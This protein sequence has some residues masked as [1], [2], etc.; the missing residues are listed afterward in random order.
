VVI[1][2]DMEQAKSKSRRAPEPPKRIT[3]VPTSHIAEESLR[4]IEAIV[5]KEKPDCIAV[6][7]DMTRFAAMKMGGGR[8]SIRELGIGSFLVFWLMK[9]IQDW[10]GKKVGIL[11]GSEMLRAVELAQKRKTM[12]FFIDREIQETFLRIK[13]IPAGEK[14]KLFFLLIKGVVLGSLFIGK[15][16]DLK[17]VPEDRIIKEAMGFLRKELPG[18]YRVLV[19]ERDEHMAR[20]LICLSRQYKNIVAVVGAGHKEGLTALLNR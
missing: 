10:L 4:K 1:K 15:K 17:K 7:L 19:E 16:I 3:L 9:K 20:Q 11:P 2:R 8:P 12:L 18:F 13:S 6:E 5:E 14:L